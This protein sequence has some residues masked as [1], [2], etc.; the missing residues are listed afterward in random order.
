M[1]RK[2][3]RPRLIGWR[4]NVMR[5][6]EMIADSFREALARRDRAGARESFQRLRN[7]VRV[8]AIRIEHEG[9]GRR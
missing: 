4:K 6:S 3:R 1:A 8:A 9:E 5:H 2:N 7:L